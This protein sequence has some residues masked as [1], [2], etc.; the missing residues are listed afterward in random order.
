M[1]WGLTYWRWYEATGESRAAEEF[2][3]ER[4]M[5]EPKADGGGWSRGRRAPRALLVAGRGLVRW[6]SRAGGE[7][8]LGGAIYSRPESVA[9]NG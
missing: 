2:S 9:V 6:W 8:R 5:P 4:M 3:P 1:K 7:S